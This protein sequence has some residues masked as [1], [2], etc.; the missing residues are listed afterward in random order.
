MIKV[1][2]HEIAE[3]KITHPL[4]RRATA[5]QNHIISTLG[6]IG[7]DVD[8]VEIPMEKIAMRK[9]PASASFYFEGRNLK[10]SYS[11]LPRFVDN[12]YIVDK[13][14]ELEIE[15]LL[16][17]EITN[18]DFTREFSEE[19]DIDDKLV[20]ARKLLEVSTDEVDMDVISKSYRKLAKKYHPDMSGGDH[21]KFQEINAAHKLIKKELM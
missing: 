18:D 16:N 11:L 4:N 5:M 14:L 19:D 17:K 8:Y 2:G 3:P 20:D 9:A 7:I 12:L 21:E 6:K 13:V 1:K 10:Y 15:K